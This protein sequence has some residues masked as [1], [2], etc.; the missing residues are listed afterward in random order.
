MDELSCRCCVI[1]SEA[2]YLS[3][4]HSMLMLGTDY[5]IADDGAIELAWNGK[6]LTPSQIAYSEDT[7]N[8]AMTLVN[9]FNQAIVVKDPKYK[10]LSVH[11]IVMR[12]ANGKKAITGR[13]DRCPPMVSAYSVWAA[14]DDVPPKLWL[15]AITNAD[16]G[17]SFYAT[18]RCRNCWAKT[19]STRLMT[20][21]E[22]QAALSPEAK[23]RAK[24]RD[25]SPERVRSKTLGAR[26]KRYA[27]YLVEQGGPMLTLD[28]VTLRIQQKF[29]DLTEAELPHFA[30]LTYA[31]YE[32]IWFSEKVGGLDPAPIEQ[33]QN[34][35]QRMT[36]K[37]QKDT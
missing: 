36:D 27:K 29:T 7:P 31:T 4:K 21:K 16:C 3:L 17:Q 23:A 8:S 15:E 34:L 35:V 22:R 13:I 19:S 18:G 33:K 12:P 5:R 14:D 28:G 9:R 24:V 30:K 1:L 20:N 26:R 10:G 2:T 6:W 37:A 11:D 25:K 32:A